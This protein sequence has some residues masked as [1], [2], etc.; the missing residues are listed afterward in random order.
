MANFTVE[1]LRPAAD[2]EWQIAESLIEELIEW[3]VLQSRGL[4]FAR[5]EIVSAFY[6]DSMESIRRNS[7]DP[8][9]RFLLA[10]RNG[11]AAGC[12][13]FRRLDSETCELY[14]VYVRRECRGH[15][16]GSLLVSR[17]QCDAMEAG[18]KAMYLETATFMHEAH[19]LYRTHQFDVR[20][21]YR[22]VPATLAGAVISMQCD[23]LPHRDRYSRG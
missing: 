1:L 10:M 22:A 2:V 20:E 4:G 6:P 18:Y 11:E 5:D 17:L 13:A 15:G 3:D 23:L 7:T 21:H 12:A 16:I 8:D 19:R 14:D 9:G